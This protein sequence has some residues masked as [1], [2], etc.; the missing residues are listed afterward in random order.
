[1]WNPAMTKIPL[2]FEA[3]SLIPPMTVGATRVIVML[4]LRS[5]IRRGSARRNG[6]IH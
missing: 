3:N 4:T 2:L 5:F 6:S 1:M